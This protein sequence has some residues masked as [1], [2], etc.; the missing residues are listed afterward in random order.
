MKR[1]KNLNQIFI[2]YLSV[3]FLRNTFDI[4][5]DQI[6]GNVDV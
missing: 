2:A 6:N 5:A 1:G 4:L 3:S